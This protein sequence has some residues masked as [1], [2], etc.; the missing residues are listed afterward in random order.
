[1]RQLD[2]NTP[3]KQMII[4]HSDVIPNREYGILTARQIAHIKQD[5]RTISYNQCGMD[6][7]VFYFRC[8]DSLIHYKRFIERIRPDLTVKRIQSFQYYGIKIDF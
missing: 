3:S 2:L 6:G 1:M 7:D 4:D 5:I 8:L